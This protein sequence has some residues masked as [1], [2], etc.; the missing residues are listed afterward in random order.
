MNGR[1][2]KQLRKD[3]EVIIVMDKEVAVW[4]QGFFTIL[5]S[6]MDVGDLNRDS[7]SARQVV[8]AIEEA[9]VNDG[10]DQDAPN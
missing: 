4:L 10:Q 3:N 1:K 8:K 7:I 5:L 6:T 2:S 9:E